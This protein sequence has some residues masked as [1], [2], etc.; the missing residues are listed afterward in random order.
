MLNEAIVCRASANL[1]EIRSKTDG[2]VIKS[3]KLKGLHCSLE[4]RGVLYLGLQS[5]Q[6]VAVD[7]TTLEII[8][9]TETAGSVNSLSLGDTPDYLVVGQQTGFLTIFQISPC[10]HFKISKIHET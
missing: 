3:L 5:K 4:A 7:T 9:Q 2:Q 6:V 1:V 10:K 8:G